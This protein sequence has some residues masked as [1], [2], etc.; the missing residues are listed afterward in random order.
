MKLRNI[1][2][3]VVLGLT[4]ALPASSFADRKIKVER[5]LDGD[6]HYN[7]KTYKVD[8]GYYG[9]G[10]YGYGNSY[11]NGGRNYRNSY[12]YGRRGYGNSYYG[13]GYGH[14]YRSYD[15]PR[16]GVSYSSRPSYYS[17]TSGY[18]RSSTG[19]SDGLAVD[20][21]R[22]LRRRGY[23]RGSLDGDIGSGSRSAIRAYQSDR[24]LA[25]TG[26]IDSRLL[27]SLNIG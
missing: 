14:G 20:V 6:G 4:L 24:G 11:G 23:Y 10:G 2:P 15:G 26:R 17:S 18:R 13:G 1:L 8:N 3:A 16:V 25:V 21:Q 12:G 9:R 7:K 19:Y 5:D 27:R 22:E